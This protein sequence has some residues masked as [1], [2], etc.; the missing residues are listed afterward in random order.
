MFQPTLVNTNCP[1]EGSDTVSNVEDESSTDNKAVSQ[2]G[3]D[4]I[5]YG[6][7][8][9]PTTHAPPCTLMNKDSRRAAQHE[10]L[11]SDEPVAMT[12]GIIAMGQFAIM[13]NCPFN[14]PQENL[15]IQSE[16]L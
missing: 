16:E 14:T 13:L 10:I 3:F 2:L 12:I 6:A 5:T 15:I 11:H 1:N 4:E 9:P 8:C 7:S